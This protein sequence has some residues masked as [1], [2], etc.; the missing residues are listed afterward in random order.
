MSEGLKTFED[1]SLQERLIHGA[2]VADGAHLKMVGCRLWLAVMCEGIMVAG[3]YGRCA[4]NKH[5]SW[6][7]LTEAKVDPFESAVNEVIEKIR[8][9]V[10]HVS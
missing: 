8:D 5:I 7:K 3:V 10:T 9:A 2:T 6:K 4:A 1:M